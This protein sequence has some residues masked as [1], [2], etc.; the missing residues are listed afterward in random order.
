MSCALVSAT[1]LATCLTYNPQDGTVRTV[2]RSLS[3]GV[4]A[5]IR[6]AALT[7]MSDGSLV[8]AVSNG[9]VSHAVRCFA[10]YPEVTSDGDVDLEVTDYSPVFIQPQQAA[11]KTEEGQ[12]EA[13][14]SKS[15]NVVSLCFVREEDSDSLLVAVDHP[16]GGRVELWELKTHWQPTHKIFSSSS[17]SSGGQDGS[18]GGSGET[19]T[20]VQAWRYVET[21][22]GP[23]PSVL[24][25][26]TPPVS[27]QSGPEAPCYV[28][29]AF[30]DG[31]I[32][33]LL[34]DSLQQVG[35]V[36]LPS[37]GGNSTSPS[38]SAGGSPSRKRKG[39]S[40]S[41]TLRSL[42][43]ATTGN[44]LVAV[45]S[46]GHLFAYRVSPISDPGGPHTVPFLATALEHCLVSGRDPWDAAAC[47]ASPA[48]LDAA[49]E[50]LQ[51][52]FSRQAP[53]VRAYYGARFTSLKLFLHR[54]SAAAA[55]GGGGGDHAAA[56]CMIG[57]LLSSVVGA[58]KAMMRT[59][60]SNGAVAERDK[61]TY[62]RISGE[63]ITSTW[64]QKTFVFTMLLLSPCFRDPPA[65]QRRDG[66]GQPGEEPADLLHP[67][68]PLGRPRRP[69]RRQAPAAV[70]GQPGAPPGLKRA[71][72]QTGEEGTGGKCIFL[73][74]LFCVS[75]SFFCRFSTVP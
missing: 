16:S 54:L 58:C 38:S 63:D 27:L 17:S 57:L 73:I 47:A 25:L 49:C 41:A 66:R 69:L 46:V 53:G 52:N 61:V 15:E 62:G 21:F 31:S 45:D 32:Q 35:S 64:T 6:L 26:S 44:A 55:G 3:G 8:A 70:D 33:C 10:L 14:V 13:S 68:G 39:E 65:Q 11:V 19:K 40:P 23:S 37:L 12:S 18:S 75:S 71:G 1:S 74:S 30:G 43:F 7:Y 59:A 5:R 34:R 20:K 36:D 2:T 28:M 4:R 56:D 51:D 29:A 67:E 22:T 9:L 42:S 72:V 24:A 50:R 60:E 48:H